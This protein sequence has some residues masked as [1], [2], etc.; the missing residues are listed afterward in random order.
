MTL[1]SDLISEWTSCSR[2]LRISENEWYY[3]SVLLQ[4]FQKKNKVCS[5]IYQL[6]DAWVH[7][8]QLTLVVG[9]GGGGRVQGTF[10]QKSC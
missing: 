4:N 8:H 2:E 3:N 5:F 1:V 7:V 10:S 6:S 9:V